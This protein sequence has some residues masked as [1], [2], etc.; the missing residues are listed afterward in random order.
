MWGE[1]GRES[2]QGG[3][4][5]G[6][7]RGLEAEGKRQSLLGRS[8]V[9]VSAEACT[10]ERVAAARQPAGFPHAS[11][12]NVWLACRQTLMSVSSPPTESIRPHSIM[13]SFWQLRRSRLSRRKSRTRRSIIPSSSP[14]WGGGG[15]GVALLNEGTGVPA[16]MPAG[17]R[18][19]PWSLS[20]RPWCHAQKRVLAAARPAAAPAGLAEAV[21]VAVLDQAVLG[22]GLAGLDVG[23]EALLVGQAALVQAHAEAHV[24]VGLELLAE[25]LLGALPADLQV[26]LALPW[27]RKKG[28]GGTGRRQTGPELLPKGSRRQATSKSPRNDTIRLPTT[29]HARGPTQPAAWMRLRSRRV[30]APGRPACGRRPP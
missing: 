5:A 13:M 25:Q 22:L 6:R 2:P 14:L 19:L 17:G 10:R 3:K 9:G 30:P 23:A 4:E 15:R 20:T 29:D 24:V 16:A 27:G 1:R 18:G 7:L 8:G 26:A 11:S 21:V 28:A 12:A